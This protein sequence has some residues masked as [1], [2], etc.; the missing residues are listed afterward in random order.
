MNCG[1]RGSPLPI[2]SGTKWL[3]QD[4]CAGTLTPGDARTGH[5]A[6]RPLGRENSR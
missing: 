2:V 4:A 6:R 3:V 5:R 1:R